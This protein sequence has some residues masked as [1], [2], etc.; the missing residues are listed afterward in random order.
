MYFKMADEEGEVELG[1][2]DKPENKLRLAS[3]FFP[4]KVGGKPAWLNLENLPNSEVFECKICKK[5][6]AFLLQVY[7][8]LN[9][10]TVD[11]Q[12]CFHRTI[13]VFCCKNGKCCKKDSSESFLALRNQL[14][15]E[16]KF[17]SSNAPPDLED[18]DSVTWDTLDPQFRPRTFACLCDTC[19]CL[20][21]KKCSK[22]HAVSYCCR[23]HQ[24]FDWKAR[25]KEVCATMS[26]E[27][28]SEKGKGEDK[29]I[30]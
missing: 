6:M 27:S 22:C 24:V 30:L 23:D 9:E 14:P 26:G 3:P 28:S 29:I 4:S 13:F 10:E 19:G 17:Y 12:R 16:N 25:H 15:R 5:P 7:A 2:V 8:P 11:D 1:F 21:D 20:G 18:D